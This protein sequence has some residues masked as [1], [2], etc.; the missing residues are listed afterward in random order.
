MCISWCSNK[1]IVS[2]SFYNQS[3]CLI[4]SNFHENSSLNNKKYYIKLHIFV[5]IKDRKKE[6][7]ITWFFCFRFLGIL[8]K[9]EYT[10]IQDHLFI[11]FSVFYL[12]IVL[13]GSTCYS[14]R[15]PYPESTT[16]DCIVVT[17]KIF[18]IKPS[19]KLREGNYY[20]FVESKSPY[21]TR[22]NFSC[23][24]LTIN[25]KNEKKR[26]KGISAAFRAPNNYT[27]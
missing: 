22:K 25:N 10:F 4:E 23:K 8:Q 2:V 13:L 7:Y 1:V 21:C 6:N 12:T 18:N 9:Y 20:V 24:S 26:N 3:A 17:D 27:Y 11:Y 16:T 15:P 5:C 14:C 19:D